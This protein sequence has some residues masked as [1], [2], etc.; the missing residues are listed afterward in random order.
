[1]P[2]GGGE[3]SDVRSSTELREVR[4]VRDIQLEK[5]KVVGKGLLLNTGNIQED[6]TA[7]NAIPER[8][9]L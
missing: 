8:I 7:T 3:G 2:K 9:S 5:Y 6:T 4:K 1:V